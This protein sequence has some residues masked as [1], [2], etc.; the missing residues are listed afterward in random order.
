MFSPIAA[1]V[2]KRFGYKK[3]ILMGLSLYSL[4]AGEF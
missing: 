4:G 1:E 3:T 2:M